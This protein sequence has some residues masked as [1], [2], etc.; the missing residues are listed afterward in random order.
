MTL[1]KL[2][3]ELKTMILKLFQKCQFALQLKDKSQVLI[4]RELETKRLQEDQ[5]RFITKNT[6]ITT[7]NILTILPQIFQSAMAVTVLLELIAFQFTGTQKN[8]KSQSQLE[9]LLNYQHVINGLPRTASQYATEISP[10][11]ALREEP[12]K[13]QEETDSRVNGLTSPNRQPY[14]LECCP[15]MELPTPCQTHMLLHSE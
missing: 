5:L 8:C 11:D 2:L 7:I 3:P 9:D 1:K 6:I 14:K 15:E 13:D 10:W 12:Q 4:A